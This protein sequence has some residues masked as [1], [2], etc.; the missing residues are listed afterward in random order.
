MD[1]PSL[2]LLGQGWRR[3][4]LG[5][6]LTDSV[7]RAC[8]LRSESASCLVRIPPDENTR[9]GQGLRKRLGEAQ[10]GRSQVGMQ[11]EWRLEPIYA[12][13]RSSQ[14]LLPAP[15]GYVPYSAA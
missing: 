6:A 3:I 8:P 4:A 1:A 14:S 15:Q 7:L 2:H 11:E 5:K 12:S 10:R 9:P 13:S